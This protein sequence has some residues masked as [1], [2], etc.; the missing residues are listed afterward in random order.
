MGS[1]APELTRTVYWTQFPA[2]ALTGTDWTNHHDAH[3]AIMRLYPTRLPGNPEQRRAGTGILYRVDTIE[4][5]LTVLIQS[6]IPPELTPSTARTLTVPEH[7]WYLPAAARIQFRVALN[8]VRRHGNQTLPVPTADIAAW[9]EKKLA[10][11]LGDVEIVNIAQS[12][13]RAR[14]NQSGPPAL[15]IATVDGLAM[16]R[17][18]DAFTHLRTHG[19]GRAKA[20]GAGL[21]TAQDI[22]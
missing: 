7:I 21:I 3:R 2:H 1:T 22:G 9:V 16:I 11:A 14:R 6:S 10:G 13:T 5:I 18:A 8:P 4:N 12:E 20:Y 15:V 19:I 17:E